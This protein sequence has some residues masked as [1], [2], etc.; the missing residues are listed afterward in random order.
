MAPDVTDDNRK[1]ADRRDFVVALEDQ[2]RSYDQAILTIAAGTLALSV[3]FAQSV[4]PKPPIPLSLV[5]L[6]LGWVALVLSL[7][8]MIWSFRASQLMLRLI[9]REQDL[10]FTDEAKAAGE[11]TERLNVRAGRALVVGFVLL[12]CYAVVNL[13]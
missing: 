1:E 7:L 4:T 10:H 9:L 11:R 3:T 13:L 5:L 12:G 2:S 6:V 8:W